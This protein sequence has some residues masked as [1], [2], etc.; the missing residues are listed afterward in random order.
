M[1][2]YVRYGA[3][4]LLTHGQWHL[5]TNANGDVIYDGEYEDDLPNGQGIMKYANGKQY[6]GVFVDGEMQGRGTYTDV[7]GSGYDGGWKDGK[8]HGH[9]TGHYWVKGY[10]ELEYEGKYVGE[11]RDGKF[12]EGTMTDKWGIECSAGWSTR[13]DSSQ[14]EMQSNYWEGQTSIDCRE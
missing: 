14:R 7:D 12:V 3:A 5:Y 11:W 2:C 9:G 8:R 4:V 13:R 6:A 1:G 10:M